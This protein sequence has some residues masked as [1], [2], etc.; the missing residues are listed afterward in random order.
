MNEH[1]KAGSSNGEYQ[2]D[3]VRELLCAYV[4]GETDREE[5]TRIE[6]ELA[7]RPD[8]RAKRE[9]LMAT[10]GLVNEF[11]RDGATLPQAAHA[12]L[13]SQVPGGAT[14]HPLV[15]YRRPAVRVA[16]ALLVA[17]GAGFAVLPPVV[18]GPRVA[19]E[20]TESVSWLTKPAAPSAEPASGESVRTYKGPSDGI[21][22]DSG[23]IGPP[24]S[25][26]DS[27]YAGVELRGLG[28]PV[29]SA[30]SVDFFGDFGSP[31]MST[32]QKQ[33]QAARDIDAYPIV[34]I[35]RSKSV[36][37]NRRDLPDDEELRRSLLLQAGY[38]EDK[39][40]EELGETQ[41]GELRQRL[42]QGDAA[43]LNAERLILDCCRRPGEAVRDMFFRHWGTRPVVQ[44][45]DDALATFAI[46]VDTAS[47][48]LARGMLDRGVLP[49]RGQVRPE[50]FVNYFE[51][52]VPSPT[53]DTFALATELAPNPFGP[54]G[55]WL[56][57]TVVQAEDVHDSERD[58]LALVFVIDVSGSMNEG[59]R[60]GLV[61]DALGQLLT[62]LD[63]RDRIALVTFSKTAQV[64]LPMTT[65]DRRGQILTAIGGLGTGGGTNVESGLLRGYELAAREF[66]PELQNRVV[67][68]SDGVGNIGETDQE[69]LLGKVSEH[70]S[71]GL[72]LNTIGFG[73]SNHNDVFLEQLADGGD[74]Q[75]NYV[76]SPVEA[77]RAFVEN[78]TGAFQTVAR[79]AK[80]QVEFDPARVG[81]Y[82][83]IGYENR[84]MAD[85]EFDQ[86]SADAGEVGAGQGVVAVFELFDVDLSGGDG[87]GLGTLR[88]RFKPPFS[89]E[90]DEVRELSQA[91][92][93]DVSR[94]SFAAASPGFRR[95][96][97]VAQTAEVLRGSWHTNGD[98]MLTLATEIEQLAAQAN[99]P[100]FREFAALFERNRAAIESA[101]RPASDSQRILDELRL[102]RYELERETEAE[103]TPEPGLIE[104]LERRIAER[105]QEL[106]DAILAEARA[107][108][109]R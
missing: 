76:D 23:G 20:S 43:R 1:L 34:G 40:A 2:R 86:D 10:I 62:K 96:T 68:L 93:A 45:A 5:T 67:L 30:S 11:A 28:R 19:S 13:A 32:D 73:I 31:S 71:K 70:R 4:L 16:A 95:S 58:S 64:L 83:L 25:S 102:L 42:V 48:A 9:R 52:G 84:A 69:E 3:E 54:D 51:S 17:V 75:C 47:Y 55:S 103:G 108:Q 79:D 12:K 37:V 106:R 91:F 82:R 100:E 92:G 38:L 81:S 24:E 39:F 21:T 105:E 74:G 50:E 66:D 87:A 29:G 88:L 14:D 98:S 78:F 60:I 46:D 63:G 15:W 80:I 99:D 101:L 56:L 109:E 61:K 33:M 59:G 72:Y 6:A 22:P 44:T 97:L 18:R 26:V 77:R 27:V 7:E 107:P 36:S 90:S 41:A 35:R 57:R 49:S 8:L 94:P 85:R 53:E 65:A 89:A 104:G